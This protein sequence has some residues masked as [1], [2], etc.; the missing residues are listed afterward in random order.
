VQRA[1]AQ[2]PWQLAGSIHHYHVT[3]QL[4]SRTGAIAV[5]ALACI[6]LAL[7]AARRRWAAWV[8]GGSLAVFA[9]TLVPFVFPHFADAVS[10]SQARRLVGFIPYP[11]AVA[12]GASVLAGLLGVV[13][14]PLALPAGIVLELATPDG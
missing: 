3:E 8:L 5:A 6:P 1:F 2:Y 10:I 13:A 7:L 9:L 12:G 4:F 14:I 11:Y